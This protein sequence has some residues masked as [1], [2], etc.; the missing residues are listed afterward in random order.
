M[1]DHERELPTI[2]SDE[3]DE[4]DGW[5]R[6]DAAP[7]ERPD[8]QE[9]HRGAFGDYGGETDGLIERILSIRHISRR[10]RVHIASGLIARCLPI[11]HATH[12]CH[13]TRVQSSN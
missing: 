7:W 5:R 13:R 8:D 11:E 12:I 4:A 3:A 2:F 6:G 9:S 10:T 1:G